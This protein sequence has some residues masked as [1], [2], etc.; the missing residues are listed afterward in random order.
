MSSISPAED[1]PSNSAPTAAG[2]TAVV[3]LTSSEQNAWRLVNHGLAWV[4]LGAMILALAGLCVLLAKTMEIIVSSANS[5]NASGSLSQAGKHLL[6]I[7]VLFI[8]SGVSSVLGMIA[9]ATGLA[10]A[11]ALSPVRATRWLLF[12][13]LASAFIA[14]YSIGNTL[15]LF[16]YQEPDAYAT[17]GRNSRNIFDASLPAFSSAIALTPLGLLALSLF[18]Q[19]AL[20]SLAN[21]WNDQPTIARIKWYLKC[22][23]AVPALLIIGGVA[24]GLLLPPGVAMILLTT[25]VNAGYVY[26][27]WLLIR[28]VYQLHRTILWQLEPER[29]KVATT[30]QVPKPVIDPLAD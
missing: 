3:P 10:F 29:A 14:I 26:L 30:P 17:Y 5:G 27:A 1:V 19:A 23:F 25:A 22:Q 2:L 11:G 6:A 24:L 8:I 7:R 21:H 13:T 28:N 16:Q 20:A 15:M 4:V 12:A 18:G 9:L